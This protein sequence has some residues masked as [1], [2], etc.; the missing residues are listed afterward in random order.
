M[1][2]RML[3]ISDTFTRLDKISNRISIFLLFMKFWNWNFSQL[4]KFH[5]SWITVCDLASSVGAEN[6]SL[7]K[8]S[9]QWN[10]LLDEWNS[11]PTTEIHW[12]SSD[13]FLRPYHK[14]S[15]EIFNMIFNFSNK[16]FKKTIH[17]LQVFIFQKILLRCQFLW[18]FICLFESSKKSKK[19]YI[20]CIESVRRRFNIWF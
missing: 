2:M 16:I 14:H 5:W 4:K 12:N 15:N 8:I 11:W 19:R 7:A 17:N 10:N 6:Q 3:L 1:V 18:L 20:Y 9:V 13:S